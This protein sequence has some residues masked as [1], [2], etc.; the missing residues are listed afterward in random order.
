MKELKLTPKKRE[1]LEELGI[2]SSLD[3]LEYYPYRYETVT[4]LPFSQW[5]LNSK[6]VVEG[7]VT[8]RP[9][10]YRFGRNKSVI[11]FELTTTENTF[12]ISVFNQIWYLKLEVGTGLVVVGRYAGQSK[13]LASQITTDRLEEVVGIKPVYSLKDKVKPRYFSQLVEKVLEENKNEIPDFIPEVFR[14]KHHLISKYE[15]LKEVH[16]PQEAAMLQQALR[17]LKYEEFLRFQCFMLQRKQ[18][19][20]VHDERSAKQFDENKL[21]EFIEN[22][23]F[24]LTSDQ[25]KSVMEI[26]ADMKAGF[27][28]CRLLQGDVGSGKTV[29]AFTAMYAAVLAGCQA[30]LMAPTEILAKQHYDNIC[31]IFAG[32]DVRCALR[33]SGLQA[34]QRQTLLQELADGTIDMIVGTHA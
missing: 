25:K 7:K 1:A 11:S 14:N 18:A 34:S 15:A 30:A 13:S 31:R 4:F 9:R 27:Q 33:Y 32:Y 24:E 12:R 3:I 28:M 8:S 29:V 6:V 19:A 17:T 20:H 5:Q 21:H 22:L 10:L 2:S 23:P 26:T 16:F